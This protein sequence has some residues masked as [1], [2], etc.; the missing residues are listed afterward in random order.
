MLKEYEAALVEKKLLGTGNV[1]LTFACEDIAKMAEPGQFVNVS[2]SLFLKRPFGIC[3]VDP[4]GNT[5]SIGVKEVGAGTQDILTASVGDVFSILGPL[6]HGFSFDGVKKIIAVG[7]GTGI[8]PLYFALDKAKRRG[9]PAICVNG[10]RSWQ[11]AFFLS[12]C[13][14]LSE[15]T[16]FASDAGDLGVKGTVM[17]ALELLQPEDLTDATVF[18]VGPEIMMKK[19]SAW[20][21]GHQLP[22]QVSLEKRMA[23]GFGICLVCVCK[24]KSDAENMPFHHVR[25]CKEGPVFQASEVIW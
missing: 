8:Y 11:D 6:G 25:C 3:M 14:E 10:F 9:I 4:I 21:H 15:K 23:C 1:L 20:A 2:C 19:V 18:V 13:E 16:I 24:I 5:F 22:C 7:G 17:D 12:E